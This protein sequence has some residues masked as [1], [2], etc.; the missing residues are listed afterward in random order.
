MA[1]KPDL[2]LQREALFFAAADHPLVV[3]DDVFEREGNL[4]PRLVLDDVG[5]LLGF[6]RRQLD[7]PRQAVLAGHR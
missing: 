7:E 4:L 2:G 6:D 1:N 3:P 5:D